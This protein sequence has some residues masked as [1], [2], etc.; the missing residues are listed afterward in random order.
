MCCTYIY[1]WGPPKL[2]ET[3]WPVN[4]TSPTD[5]DGALD[6]GDA[7]HP[8]RVPPGLGG[9]DA[10]EAAAAATQGLSRRRRRGGG[11]TEEVDGGSGRL[12]AP[13]SSSSEEGEFRKKSGTWP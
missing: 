2:Y 11:G 5:P 3:F 12:S 9:G 4:A 10:A 1:T 7:L 13:T 8:V 6:G